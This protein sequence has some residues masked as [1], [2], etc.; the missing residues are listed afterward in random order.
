[1]MCLVGSDEY[2]LYV[3]LFSCLLNIIAIALKLMTVFHNVI[4]LEFSCCS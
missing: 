4:G 2:V 3:Q 1:M